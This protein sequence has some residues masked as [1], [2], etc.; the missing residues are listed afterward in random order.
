MVEHPDFFKKITHMHQFFKFFHCYVRRQSYVCFWFQVLS[1]NFILN[2]GFIVWSMSYEEGSMRW[3]PAKQCCG[4]YPWPKGLQWMMMMM[5]VRMRIIRMM[6]RRRMRMRFTTTRPDDGWASFFGLARSWQRHA[7]EPAT[8]HRSGSR[9]NCTSSGEATCA[10][11][12]DLERR[13]AK[14]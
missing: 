1:K 6:I 7:V 9:I 13:R 10:Q 14:T 3:Y 2:H 8:E 4:I 12:F 11:K 5:M